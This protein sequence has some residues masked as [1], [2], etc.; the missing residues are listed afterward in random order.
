MAIRVKKL[1]RELRTT[2]QVVLQVLLEL[3]YDRYKSD[4]DMVADPPAHKVR[5]R[6]KKG[7]PTPA[8]TPPPRAPVARPAPR[9][10]APPAPAWVQDAA[11]LDV[12]LDRL[13]GAPKPSKGTDLAD[14]SAAVRKEQARLDK[15]DQ[16]QRAKSAHLDQQLAEVEARNAAL[17]TERAA[18]LAELEQA[19][20]ALDDRAAALDAREAG[21]I[22][23]QDLLARRGLSGVDEQGR[24]LDALARARLLDSLAPRLRVLDPAPVV[25]VL[26]ER[27]V[28]SSGPVD[29]L[30]GVAV[31][32]VPADRAE[33]PGGAQLKRARSDLAGEFLLNGLTRVRLIGGGPVALRLLRAGVDER[34][35]LELVPSKSRDEAQALTDVADV[36]AVVLWDVDESPQATEAYDGS[37]VVVV[38]V[39]TKGFQALVSGVRRA[40]QPD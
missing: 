20:Q 28:L 37:D 40:L 24:A 13:V 8:V 10:P 5:Q 22:P 18:L 15:R 11:A 33:V 4:M 2:P 6:A 39:P 23:L 25:A 34:V 26:Q 7:L 29:D 17:R 1:A 12:P 27:L 35:S 14:V 16:V 9:T 31:V 32:Q 36:D 19:R 3:G 38:R 21:G 30:P